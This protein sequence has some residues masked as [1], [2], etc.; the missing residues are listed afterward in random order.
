MQEVVI[1]PKT[2]WLGLV[3]MQNSLLK[4]IARLEKGLSEYVGTDEAMKI[5]GIGR[6]ALYNARIANK[7]EFKYEGRKVLY[8]RSSLQ[9]YN[10]SNRPKRNQ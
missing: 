9:A 4:R 6:D 1:I 7:I 10:E 3:E 5:T 8:L 2:E